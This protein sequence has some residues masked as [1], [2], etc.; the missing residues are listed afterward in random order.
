MGSRF[1]RPRLRLI[2]AINANSSTQPSRAEAPESCAMPTGPISWRGDASPVRSS[3]SVM[4]MR[5]AVAT[6][7]LTLRPRASIGTGRVRDRLVT[8]GDADDRVGPTLDRRHGDRHLGAASAHEDPGR[9][10][11][12]RLQRVGHV[13]RV[14]HPLALDRQ[15]HVALGQAGLLGRIARVHRVDQRIGVGKHADRADL[16]GGVRLHRHLGGGRPDGE[17]ALVAAAAHARIPRRGRRAR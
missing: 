9:L 2:D 11:G 16:E 14:D 4:R 15:D 12:A 7:R 8:Q 17:G 10:A 13:A 3:P 6:L 5:P 1:N